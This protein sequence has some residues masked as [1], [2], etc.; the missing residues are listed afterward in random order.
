[1]MSLHSMVR[2][3]ALAA[4]GALVMPSSSL[5]ACDQSDLTGRWQFWQDNGFKVQFDLVQDAAGQIRGSGAH[6]LRERSGTF[7]GEYSGRYAG[8]RER[9]HVLVCCDWGG[10]RGRYDGTVNADGTFAG[11]RATVDS[12]PTV[13]FH[14]FDGRKAA[15]VVSTP[16]SSASAPTPPPSAALQIQKGAQFGKMKD[17]ATAIDD[18]DIHAGP[19]GQFKKLGVLKVGGTGTVMGHQ[20]GWYQLR[21]LSIDLVEPVG[22]I[23]EDHLKV[24]RV[25][26]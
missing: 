9:Q 11:T 3:L 8:Q 5:A 26:R 2:A 12:A 25:G 24:K 17:V 19:G 6:L 18:V 16:P 15:C 4:V 22:W 21:D 1:M 10:N 7:S 13:A 23:A 14:E 20:P